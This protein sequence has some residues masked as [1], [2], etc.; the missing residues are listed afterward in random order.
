MHYYLCI[1]LV[2]AWAEVL[3]ELKQ[4]TGKYSVDCKVESFV[5]LVAYDVERV[6]NTDWRELE[7]WIYLLNNQWNKASVM[8]W[9]PIQITLD[10]KFTMV[11]H[12]CIEMEVFEVF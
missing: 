3:F 11:D 4:L 7:Q 10:V 2:Q 9:Q 1:C 8:M 6:D 12:F 5:E